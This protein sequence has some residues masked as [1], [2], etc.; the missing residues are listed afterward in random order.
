M[1]RR[2]VADGHDHHHRRGQQR[3]PQPL[4]PGHPAMARP[5]VDGQREQKR[6]HQ[7]RLHQQHR[8]EAERRRL[9][10]EPGR[11]DQAS[12]PPLPVSEQ[13]GEQLEVV[14]LLVGDLV[15]GAL[16]DDVADRDEEGRAEGEQGGDI[17]LGHRCLP[18]SSVTS[19]GKWRHRRTDGW[20]PV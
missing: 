16:V 1:A 18:S 10:R 14:H 11:R 4:P 13:P 8:S 20:R 9:Q 17:R 19:L 7:E 15:C 12:E 2:R 5:R 6:G 3:R